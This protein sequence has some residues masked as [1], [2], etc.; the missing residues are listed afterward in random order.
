M[1]RNSVVPE[2]MM[3]EKCAFE[4]TRRIENKRRFLSYHKTCVKRLQLIVH[5][6]SEAESGNQQVMLD[7]K[8]RHE[9]FNVVGK[10][11]P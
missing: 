6:A 11:T 9:L 5:A 1:R 10:G 4:K 8:V 7:D 2:P 3:S